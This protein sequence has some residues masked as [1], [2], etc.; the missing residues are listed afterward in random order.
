[1][2]SR[3]IIVEIFDN[4]LKM[5]AYYNIEIKKNVLIF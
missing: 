3:K 4:V 1:M 2:N 5:G